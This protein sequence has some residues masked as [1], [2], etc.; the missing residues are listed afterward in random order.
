MLVPAP[1]AGMLMGVN[2]ALRPNGSPLIENA[3]EELKPP[4]TV[5]V[6]DKRELLPAMTLIDAGEAV[7]LSAG[8]VVAS[9]QWITRASASTEPRPVTRS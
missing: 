3:T 1:G 2:E 8:T 9:F 6:T 5:V 4:L 7:R